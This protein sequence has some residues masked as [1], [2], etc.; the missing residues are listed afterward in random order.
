VSD[1]RTLLSRPDDGP[2]LAAAP[3]A[4]RGLVEARGLGLI[5]VDAAEPG[6]LAA[7]VEMSVVEQ[8]RLPPARNTDV[9]GFTLP[10]L[11]RVDA[12]WFPDALILWLRSAGT[13]H[14]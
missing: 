10:L 4:I 2:P 9:L 11:R 13:G 3:E 8:E 12:P 14:T 1:D 7:V 5:R 6:R